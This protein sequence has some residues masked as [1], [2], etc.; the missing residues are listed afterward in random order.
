[1]LCA[2]EAYQ[3]THSRTVGFDSIVSY[4]SI[5]K[6]LRTSQDAHSLYRA[7]FIESATRKSSCDWVRVSDKTT[8]DFW[9]IAYEIAVADFPDLAMKE[10][11]LTK[12]STWITFLPNDM[13]T[14][15]V[16][17]Y[18]SAQCGRGH[19]DLTF[20]KSEYHLFSP[21][22]V[23]ILE[24]GMSVISVGDSSA[25]RIK[26]E[27]FKVG[28]VDEAVRKRIRGAFGASVRRIKFFR[29]PRDLLTQAADE[30]QPNV[31]A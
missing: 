16:W 14:M 24:E 28:E 18:V 3:K 23:G 21:L 6:F 29:S 8:D 22:V 17:I 12:D 5:A 26:V 20:T 25:I 27:G 4:E 1:V 10:L 15:P 9:D 30:T 7:D 11:R 31:S 13:P 2:P 19:M